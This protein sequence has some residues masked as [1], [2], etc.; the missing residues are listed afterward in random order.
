MCPR[1]NP[2]WIMECFMDGL[3]IGGQRP[4]DPRTSY[5][6]PRLCTFESRGGLCKPFF[7]QT[8]SHLSLQV[9]N[10]G[11]TAWHAVPAQL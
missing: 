3:R 9:H 1:P 7:E 5:H 2:A 10:G 6:A 11:L 8:I 4:N